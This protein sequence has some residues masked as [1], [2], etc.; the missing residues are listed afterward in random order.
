MREDD[1]NMEAWQSSHATSELKSKISGSEE[2]EIFCFHKRNLLE[3]RISA[4]I[5]HSGGKR[6]GK[7][8]MEYTETDLYSNAGCSGRSADVIGDISADDAAVL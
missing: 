5:E 1:S 2:P 8:K 4:Q 6:N 7:E 3:F